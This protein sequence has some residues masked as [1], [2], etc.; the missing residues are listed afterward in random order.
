MAISLFPHASTQFLIE[1][2]ISNICQRKK[3]WKFIDVH[4]VSLKTYKKQHLIF[5]IFGYKW[6]TLSLYGNNIKF[7]LGRN[8]IQ[9][10]REINTLTFWRYLWLFATLNPTPKFR[11]TNKLLIKDLRRMSML[12]NVFIYLL[13]R[14]SVFQYGKK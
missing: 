11:T 7:I 4:T 13:E 12:Q 5:L 10:F 1:I 9:Y 6:T 8:G 14:I 2:S 3:K